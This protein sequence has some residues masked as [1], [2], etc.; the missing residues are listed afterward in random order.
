[1][2]HNNAAVLKVYNKAYTYSIIVLLVFILSIVGF[3]KLL[4]QK[5]NY[6]VM[7]LAERI[8]EESGQS[9]SIES[10]ATKWDWFF[11]K[12]NLKN[13]QILDKKD[14]TPLLTA[15]EIIGTVD[16]LSSIR[17]CTL[18]F[19]QL[20]LRNPH[21]SLSMPGLISPTMQG[22]LN[23]NVIA[24]MLAMQKR[25][26]IEGGH[27]HLQNIN[28]DALPL[29][30]I[31]L[32]FRKLSDGNYNI[33]MRGNLAV[34]TQ[35]EFIIAA[36]Y[37]GT[38]EHYDKALIDF[39]IK[40]SH[41]QVAE[42]F[43][44]LP[45][46]ASRFID[47]EFANFDIR[48]MI[49]NGSIKNIISDFSIVNLNVNKETSIKHGAGHIEYKADKQVLT[50]Q[51]NN[52]H[53]LN[54]RLYSQPVI[55]NSINSDIFYEKKPNNNIHIFSKNMH[56]KCVD[57][58]LYPELLISSYG[59]DIDS[60]ELDIILQDAAPSKLLTLLPDKQLSTTLINWLDG[61]LLS[62]E[63][64]RIK[65]F[66][67]DQKLSW[68]LALKDTE[69]KFSQAWPSITGINATLLMNDNNLSL[70]VVD[71]MIFG[72]KINSLHTKFM[73]DRTNPYAK[74]IIDGS[75]DTDLETCLQYLRKTPLKEKLVS[76][77]EFL[78]PSGNIGLDL[79]LQFNLAK[80]EI[81][82]AV[83]GKI[84][85]RQANLF[86]DR[87]NL[88]INNLTGA[89]HFKNDVLYSDKLK[90]FLLGQQAI[91]V[92]STQ[93]HTDP[94]LKIDIHTPV[95]IAELGKILPELNLS[96]MDGVT[97]VH[98]KIVLPTNQNDPTQTIYI[99]SDLHGISM[100][101]PSPFYKAAKTRMPFNIQLRLNNYNL[102]TINMN[103]SEELLD[104]IFFF[105]NNKLDGARLAIGTKLEN[106]NKI[107]TM[108]I[109][110]KLRKVDW[111]E[112]SSLLL[113]TKQNSA[114]PIELDLSIASLIL[115]GIDFNPIHVKYLSEKN[116]LWFDSNIATGSITI[117]KLAEKIDIKLD[118]MRL[119]EVKFTK[120]TALERI[121]EHN[122][123]Q[124]LPKIQFA[125]NTLKYKQLT[126][127][128]VALEL[129]P[130]PYGYE[131]MNFSISNKNILMQAQG[132]WRIGNKQVTML[133]GNAFTQDFGKVLAEWG[134]HNSITKGKGEI[135]F[136]LQWDGAPN[137]FDI[138]K[139]DGAAHLD[140]R[141]GSFT[142]VN[143]GLGRVI[144][145]LSLE[146]IQ[147][148]LQLDFSDILTRGFAFDK[149]VADFK[150]QMGKISSENIHINSPAAKIELFGNTRL[151]VQALDLT[152]Y[153]IPKVGAGLPIAAAIAAGNPVVGAAVW[154]FDKASGSKLSEITKYKYKVTGTWDMPQIDEVVG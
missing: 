16:I 14:A 21:L 137:D 47:G 31:K 101:Y 46:N 42:L 150:M 11:L 9:V 110:G 115:N 147:R 139:V 23:E 86:I 10:I 97:N 95:K 75:I 54:N 12:I 41:I 131:I 154:L 60:I 108:R 109:I 77:L 111:Q 28:G 133:S 50:L 96:C 138:L 25:I 80:P 36:K 81:R 32:D 107:S 129:F 130:R 56:I 85:L 126:F 6:F 143:P 141:S 122:G 134:Y 13:I 118:K 1:M 99:K 105:A 72:N 62:G 106:H 64:Q 45:K 3:G 112:W 79:N 89:L 120:P 114:L 39:E 70:N 140:M 100:H 57:L 35:P 128:K 55:I 43:N 74:I 113:L 61:A 30:D 5:V 116:E 69:L 51:L 93:E 146:T 4:H 26:S 33:V 44:I 82:V 27:I 136:S 148:R 8:S 48:G 71:A 90:L 68:S 19:Q 153:V 94:M 15:S 7:S 83:D 127:N 34:S 121:F 92:I 98:A 18:K 22:G 87:I 124:N 91:A 29:Q 2:L 145:L 76:K 149:F 52:L 102:H 78:K 117:D 73:A 49:E 67:V 37:L 24:K 135:N 151:N 104:G 58:E 125:C 65:L 63:V 53:L 144:S 119:P 88:P 40:T 152:M 17:S 103:L 38:L 59:S 84:D 123:T 66:Y 142:N 132:S 20:S